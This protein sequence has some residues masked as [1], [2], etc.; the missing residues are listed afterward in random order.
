MKSTS[1]SVSR[2]GARLVIL[3]VTLA[4][5]LLMNGQEAEGVPW[6]WSHDHVVFSHPGTADE[7][8]QKGAYEHWLEDR[9]R[10]PLHDPAT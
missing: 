7:A 3:S 10:S 4:S 6:D 2:L 5:T 8:I 1:R 9:R